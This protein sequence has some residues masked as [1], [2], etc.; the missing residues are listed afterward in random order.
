[1]S[2]F[3]G[4]EPLD[5][6]RWLYVHQDEVIGA[7]RTAAVELVTQAGL[8][9]QVV[10]YHDAVSESPRAHPDRIRLF[11]GDDDKVRSALSG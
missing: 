9:P 11:L 7:G 2:V 6:N 10:R 1:M 5:A 3:T 8:L 4:D